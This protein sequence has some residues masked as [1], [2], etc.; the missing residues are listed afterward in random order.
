MSITTI[1]TVFCDGP[2]DHM[3]FDSNGNRE[4]QE[5]I[6]E[7]W[8]RADAVRLALQHGWKIKGGKHYCPKCVRELGIK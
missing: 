3:A 8:R 1:H 7:E 6:G 5:W 2:T 4:S